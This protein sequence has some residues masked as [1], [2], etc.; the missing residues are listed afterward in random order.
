LMLM[1]SV[2]FGLTL[3]LLRLWA[4]GWLPGW[5]GR[6]RWIWRLRLVLPGAWGLGAGSSPR[7]P[8]RT[9]WRSSGI[10]IG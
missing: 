2:C 4:G 8:I 10:W 5:S 1:L 6:M 3:L 7:S 9:G